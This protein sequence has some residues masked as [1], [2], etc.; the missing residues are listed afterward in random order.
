M[1]CVLD[2]DTLNALGADSLF[3]GGTRSSQ[4]RHHHADGRRRSVTL[5]ND[6]GACAASR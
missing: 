4:R 1:R 3:I 5:A 6:A 2:A